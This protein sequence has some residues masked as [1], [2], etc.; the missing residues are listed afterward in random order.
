MCVIP[1]TKRHYRCG[2]DVPRA[3]VGKIM[4]PRAQRI[5]HSKSVSWGINLERTRPTIVKPK[6]MLVTGVGFFAEESW[7]AGNTSFSKG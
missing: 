3:L 4:A 7:N 2:T 5:S 1:A 6:L